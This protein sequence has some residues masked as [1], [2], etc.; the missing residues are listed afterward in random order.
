MKIYGLI[1]YPLTHSFSKKYFNE[2]FEKEGLIQ[3]KYENFPIK[4]IDELSELIINNKEICGLN[5]T[6]PYKEKVI[7]FLDVIDDNARN[8]GAVNTIKITRN[9]KK[10][11]MSGFN[12]DAYGF[13]ESLKPLINNNVKN[14]LILGTG[15]ASK[16]VAY[17][18]DKLNIRYFFVTRNPRSNNHFAYSD[19]NG[20]IINDCQLIINTSPVGMFPDVNSYPDIPYVYISEKHILYDLIY[21][22]PETLFLQRGKAIGAKTI[23][24]LPMLHL[25]AEKAWEI[26]NQ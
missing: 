17:V 7:P 25:Q 9:G 1:G 8:I 13:E 22:P 5:V 23:N 6:I 10:P 21:N 24:G 18:L 15:G 14:A 2:K 20:K 12:T 16:A 26:W 11:V 3:C 19:L 4:S